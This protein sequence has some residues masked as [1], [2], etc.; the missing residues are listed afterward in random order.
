MSTQ[1]IAPGAAAHILKLLQLAEDLV[2]RDEKGDA[3]ATLAKAKKCV[4]LA[5]KPADADQLQLK[6]L[7]VSA[8][9]SIAQAD[10]LI[11]VSAKALREQRC[12]VDN[13]VANV[14]EESAW[15]LL[16]SATKGLE[17][18]ERMLRGAS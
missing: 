7:V 6:R 11:S 10:S 16:D 17:E 12:E 13:D 5:A 15:K 2:N 1:E 8:A 3:L 4:E 18:A 14:L 9:C